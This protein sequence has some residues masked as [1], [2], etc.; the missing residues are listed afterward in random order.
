MPIHVPHKSTAS[1]STHNSS[2]SPCSLTIESRA[3]RMSCSNSWSLWQGGLSNIYS[4]QRSVCLTPCGISIIS[5][6]KASL[7]QEADTTFLSSK[8]SRRI[9]PSNQSSGFTPAEG[10]C[11][12]DSQVGDEDDTGCVVLEQ[13]YSQLFILREPRPSIRRS[14]VGRF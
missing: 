7:L 11:M 13:I 2:P 1:L 3:N 4:G 14:A 5:K 8:P 12:P 9:Q 6:V 10:G